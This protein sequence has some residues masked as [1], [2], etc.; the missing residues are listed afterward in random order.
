MIR[1]KGTVWRILFTREAGDP[2]QV[3]RA[4]EGRFH[5][6]GQTAIYTSL[7]PQGA[8]IAIAAYI[9]AIDPP[10]LLVPLEVEVIVR[11]QRA[12]P[13]PTAASFV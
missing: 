2:T 1:F 5:H 8:R 6:N 11:D 4:P 9:K 3:A 7:T 13:D 12:V 10:R